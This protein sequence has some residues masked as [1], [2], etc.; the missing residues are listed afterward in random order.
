MNFTRKKIAGLLLFLIFSTTAVMAQT[1]QKSVSDE[2]I[3]RF[4]VTFQ[5]MRMMNQEMQRGM[6][7]ILSKEGMEI[8]RFNEIHKAKLDPAV[9]VE[10]SEEEQ[11]KYKKIKSELD[12][13]Q[14]SFSE[15]MNKMISESEL[16]SERYQEIAT[17]LQTDPKLQ[18]RLKAEFEQ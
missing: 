8:A 3:S 4:A 17:R 14:L 11:K 9:T 10:P 13:L 2:E 1:E 15:K 6:A 5:K 7:E 16:T 12:K 18:E